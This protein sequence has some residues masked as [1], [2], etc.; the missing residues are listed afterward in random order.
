MVRKQSEMDVGIDEIFVDKEDLKLAYKELCIAH[1]GIADFR[2]KL[3]AL[4][5]PAPEFFSS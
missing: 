2:A 4:L 5:P 1:H 3:L